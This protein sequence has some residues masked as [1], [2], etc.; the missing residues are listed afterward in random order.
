MKRVEDFYSK[1]SN[2]RWFFMKNR[3][4]IYW[5]L[6]TDNYNDKD[7]AFASEFLESLLLSLIRKHFLNTTIKYI[8]TLICL[9]TISID[10]TLRLQ[11]NLHAQLY[12]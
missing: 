8:H 1:H 2:P 10:E 3:T 6:L 7:E 5:S 9:T 11:E 4:H 12:V